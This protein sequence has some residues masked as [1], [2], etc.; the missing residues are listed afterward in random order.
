MRGIATTALGVALLGGLAHANVDLQWRPVEQT[1][2]LGEIAEIGLYAV[3]DDPEANQPIASIDVLPGWDSDY[4]QLLDVDDNGPYSW[5]WSTFPN[6]SSGDGV[7]DTWED[8][9]AKYTALAQFGFGNEAWATPEG[10]LV[11]TFQFLTLMETL[12]E[13]PTEVLTIA[14]IGDHSQTVVRPPGGGDVTGDMADNALITIVP[15]P[16]IVLLLL[17]G[18]LL[19]LRRWPLMG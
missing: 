17:G 15:E 7:N 1:V 13:E 14:A 10:L 19:W 11:T 6:D 9:D 18:G 2:V 16:S 4:L 8:G 3:S 12:A 5:W